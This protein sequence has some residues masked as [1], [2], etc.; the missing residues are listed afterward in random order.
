MGIHDGHRQ[1]LH[2]RVVEHGLDSLGDHEL[3]EYLLA[4][5]LP[6][7]DTNATAHRL[8]DTFGSYAGVLDAPPEEL[9]KIDGMGPKSAALIHTL[10]GA[11]RRYY[12]CQ[13]KETILGSSDACGAYFLPRY[14][15]RTVETVFLACLDN[16][17]RVI[18]CKLLYEGTVNAADIST[19]QVL[20]AALLHNAAAVV[21]AHNHPSG[22]ALPSPEDLATTRKLAEALAAVHVALVDHIIVANNDFVSM[23][24]SNQVPPIPR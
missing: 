6:R 20:Q 18:N 15:G 19:R 14:I 9:A 10:S 23:A 16:K 1:R 5:V 2:Q 17:Y 13:Q 21:L 12:V 3:L 22:I 24:D 8:M 4:F 7:V 11:T